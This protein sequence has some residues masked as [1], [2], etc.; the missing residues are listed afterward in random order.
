M[1]VWARHSDRAH[2]R[3]WHTAIAAFVAAAGMMACFFVTSP[4]VTMIALS[5]SALGVFGLKGPFLSAISESFSKE[6]AAVGIAMIVSIGN[7][8]GSASPWLIG[9]VKEHMGTYPPGLVAVGICSLIGGLVM[10][11]RPGAGKST[12]RS[13]G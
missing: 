12:E 6:T 3:K 2:E 7:L 11:G 10:L 13:D 5:V 4:L 9:Y 1:I 8:A